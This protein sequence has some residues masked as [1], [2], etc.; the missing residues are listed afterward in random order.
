MA[1][2][3]ILSR[4]YGDQY[5]WH[6]IA[7]N[8]VRFSYL[9]ISIQ[10]ERIPLR[11]FVQQMHNGYRIVFTGMYTCTKTQW[12]SAMHFLTL[13]LW[14][15]L[16]IWWSACSFTCCPALEVAVPQCRS[17]AGKLYL[18]HICTAT[19]HS[20]SCAGNCRWMPTVWVHCA[21]HFHESWPCSSAGEVSGSK[22][23]GTVFPDPPH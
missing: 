1:K 14:Y 17:S 13:L 22:I 23:W 21:L 6:V 11:F 16:L 8:F 12:L 19:H 5:Q 4:R 7:L 10:S 9:G 20:P 2:V 3:H 15:R 18:C